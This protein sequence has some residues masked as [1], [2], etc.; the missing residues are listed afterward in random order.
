MLSA[1]KDSGNVRRDIMKTAR[2]RGVKWIRLAFVDIAGIE[3]NI[4]IPVSELE[5]A[6]S[7]RVT[8]DGG[9]IDGFIREEEL[10]M[11]LR[12]DAATFAILPWTIESSAPEARMLCARNGRPA[13][14]GARRREADREPAWHPRDVHAQADQRRGRAPAR[15]RR[16]AGSRAGF[17]RGL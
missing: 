15:D 10:D 14:H 9:S 16:F 1:V 6:M 2:D 12:P 7:G 5:R 3:K 11:L 17:H 13:D 8:F 4:T